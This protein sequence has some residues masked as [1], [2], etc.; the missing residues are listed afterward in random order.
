MNWQWKNVVSWMDE[1]SY[2]IN[3]MSIF[4]SEIIFMSQNSIKYFAFQMV[5]I[6]LV[7]ARGKKNANEIGT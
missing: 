7:S 2:W 6:G 1:L 5:G 4:D 3:E